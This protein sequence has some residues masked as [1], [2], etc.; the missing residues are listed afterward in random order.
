MAGE[1]GVIIKLRRDTTTEWVADNPI[2]AEG[3]TGW[4]QDT[5]RVK[6]GD[7]VTAWN[8]LPYAAGEAVDPTVGVFRSTD[9]SFGLS[10]PT[11]VGAEF[12]IVA[13]AL[14]DIRYDG[15]SL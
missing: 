15:V 12:I 5:G 13:D 2:L 9:A 8:D 7:G 4:E 3:E 6:L 10:A 1:P 14:D 11:G